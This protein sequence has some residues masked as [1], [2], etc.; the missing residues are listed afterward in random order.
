MSNE[1]AIVN[2]QLFVDEA[3]QGIN[4]RYEQAEKSLYDLANY[5]KEKVE[6]GTSYGKSK[7]QVYRDLSSHKDFKLKP[8]SLKSYDI[9][10]G[11][12]EETGRSTDLPMSTVQRIAESKLEDEDKQVILQVAEDKQM[13]QKQVRSEIKSFQK[14]KRR[15]ER[16]ELGKTV[17]VPAELYNADF[18]NI[19]MEEGSV[20][21]VL[22]DPPYPEEFLPLWS[23]LA[24][25]AAD[26]LKP[27]GFLA[28][29][30]G[31]LHLPEVFQRLSEHLEYYWTFCLYHVGG[32]QI[33]H[34]RGVMCRWKPIL[35]FQKPPFKKTDFVPQD[36]V[37][38]EKREKDGHEW[39]QSESAAADLIE[40]FSK[41]GD[42]VLDPFM[43][44]GT[45]PY[46]A[47]KLDRK[48]IGIEIDEQSFLISKSRFND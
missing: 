30:S 47:D 19:A 31:Q 39:Q 11:F 35:I 24:K 38:S 3:V 13:T 22:T 42:T 23:D 4:N 17:D 26:V 12:L 29:Y 1:N 45:F 25:T 6:E 36:Y 14:E 34:P 46:V 16:A 10:A 18:R 15:E 48:A 2:Y 43:G 28:C 5:V 33:V 7:E 41:P 21:L 32:T 9:T 27:S 44:A 20:D 40:I 37:V 8:H